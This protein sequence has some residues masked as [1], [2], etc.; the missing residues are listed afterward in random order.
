MWV[1][2]GGE[3][4]ATATGMGTEERPGWPRQGGDE[5]ETDHDGR[6][7]ASTPS[8]ARSLADGTRTRREPR[9]ITGMSPARTIE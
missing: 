8:M 2:N 9:R 5:H 7:H 3:L 1:G 4:R 6:A